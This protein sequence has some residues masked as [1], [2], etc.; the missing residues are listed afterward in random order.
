MR[1]ALT[2]L[3]CCA[4]TLA[5][6]LVAHSLREPPT[7]AGAATIA[8][9]QGMVATGTAAITTPTAAATP[10]D[11]KVSRQ[12]AIEYGRVQAEAYGEA[13]P[14]LIEVVETTLADANARLNPGGGPADGPT[15]PVAPEDTPVWLVRM[16]GSFVASRLP[17]HP[18]VRSRRR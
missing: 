16:W 17:P 18:S 6:P 3:T 7:R 11:K 9:A 14:V 1:F 13:N 5:L 2:T 4:V 12:A 10:V 8:P 15:L